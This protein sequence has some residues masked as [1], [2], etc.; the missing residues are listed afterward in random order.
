MGHKSGRTALKL[1]AS[2][3]MIKRKATV[4]LYRKPT[5]KSR[6]GEAQEIPPGFRGVARSESKDKN[7][8]DPLISL[9]CKEGHSNRKKESLKDRGSQIAS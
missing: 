5:R 3:V 8:G 2:T 6:Y 9:P 4:S 7:M 1:L